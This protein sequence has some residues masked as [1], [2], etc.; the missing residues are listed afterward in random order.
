M[1]Q[2]IS[3]CKCSGLDRRS[4]SPDK[5]GRTLSRPCQRHLGLWPRALASTYRPSCGT[6]L[7]I[8]SP[9]VSAGS[10]G[11]QPQSVC[12]WLARFCL[13]PFPPSSRTTI[14][15]RNIF[16][17]NSVNENCFLF[18]FGFHKTKSQTLH[19]KSDFFFFFETNFSSDISFD[20][21]VDDIQSF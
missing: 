1:I 12:R 8:V 5:L 21:A 14:L 7:A 16:N 20:L 13:V 9:D 3:S 15:Q 19:S 11:A 6:S 10:F 18:A 4:H 17:N 2:L